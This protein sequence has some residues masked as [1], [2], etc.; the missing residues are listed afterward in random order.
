MGI[1][2]DRL[3]MKNLE[4]K[5][6]VKALEKFRGP[7]KLEAELIM[8]KAKRITPVD[9]GTL[10]SSGHVQSPKQT[11]DRLSITLGFGGAASAYALVQHERTDYKHR[12]KQQAKFLEQP[13]KEEELRLARR[14]VRNLDLW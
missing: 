13:V 9:T 1:Q 10:R 11:L 8:T 7:L 4:K 5:L 6:D 14:L 2:W 12:G 3:D